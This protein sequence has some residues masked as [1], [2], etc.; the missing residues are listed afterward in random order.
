M[1]S[2]QG[3]EAQADALCGVITVSNENQV[4]IENKYIAVEVE[5]VGR[6]LVN[7]TILDKVNGRTYNLGK[8]IFRLEVL[9]EQTDE[10]CSKKEVAE[11]KHTL[12]ASDL[13]CGDLAV[14]ELPAKP[15]ARRLVERV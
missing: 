14:D 11:T 7:V 4:M 2:A 5:K 10:A 1:T 3:A 6:K 12:T 8:D 13:I 9:D 15:E